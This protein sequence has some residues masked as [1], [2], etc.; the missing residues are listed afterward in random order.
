MNLIF[1]CCASIGETNNSFFI[2]KTLGSLWRDDVVMQSTLFFL[3]L[4]SLVSSLFPFS[5]KTNFFPIHREYLPL[6]QFTISIKKEYVS[7]KQ[8]ISFLN[9]KTIYND[10]N[11]IFLSQKY[12]SPCRYDIL[13]WQL[14]SLPR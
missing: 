2:I 14:Y 1:V 7:L 11:A 12:S 3:L 9:L 8:H 13:P 4:V 6:W 10:M 5:N